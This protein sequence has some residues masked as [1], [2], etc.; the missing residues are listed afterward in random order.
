MP[1]LLAIVRGNARHT[2]LGASTAVLLLLTVWAAGAPAAP[3]GQITEFSTGLNAGS[4][5]NGIAPGPDG[6]LWFT[7]QGTTRA[8]GRITPAGTITE[9]SA[10]L[11]PGSFP[12]G[13]ASGPDGN[14]WFP[15]QGTTRAIG[16]ITPA[17]T[18]TEF[19]AGLNP[20]SGPFA[21]APGP[22][23]NLWFADI[24][25][26]AIGRITPAGTIDEFTAGL[27]AG[28]VPRAIAPGPDGNVWFADQGST[29]A[30]GR[31]TPAGTID[32]LS[33][34]LAGVPVGIAPGADGNLWFADAGATPAVGRISPTGTI[35]EF[36][37]GFDP[38][39]VPFAIAPGPDGNLWFVDSATPAIGRIGA[40]AP[41]PSLDAPR[42]TGSGQQGTQQVCQGDRWATWAGQQP[43]RVV[44]FS[45]QGYQWL[46]D[47]TPI[48]GQTT[49]T[50]TPVAGDVGHNLSCTATV[51]YSLF[52]VTTSATSPSITV[53]KQSSGPPGAQGPQGATGPQ[54]PPGRDATVTC[55]AK[56]K[57]KVKCKVAFASAAGVR[58]ARLSRDGV[59][60]AEGKPVNRGGEFVLRFR[61]AHRLSAG[62]YTL[63]VIQHLDGHR[64]VTKSA[65]RIR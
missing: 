3:T 34:G 37:A 13:I 7:D 61:S 59:T 47:G 40:G 54:G 18:I 28:S 39:G 16:R 45:G 2:A 9:F 62:R 25:S 26:P 58:K 48:A 36:S 57:K 14:V 53:I 8:I 41:P 21:I 10:G 12:R 27:N 65:V 1:R 60:Y 20:G 50:Y 46:R 24:T 31:I 35:S 38:G 49:Q 63:T 44:T 23:G 17:G 15:D 51:R 32:E 19:S 22:D 29:P 11:S 4:F 33:A 42:V 55:K 52:E 43:L 64:V 30:I 56:G 6:N 5:L